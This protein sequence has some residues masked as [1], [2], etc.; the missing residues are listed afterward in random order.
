LPVV[1]SELSFGHP[2]SALLIEG[3]IRLPEF[4]Q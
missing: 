1:A 3:G 4:D 2:F